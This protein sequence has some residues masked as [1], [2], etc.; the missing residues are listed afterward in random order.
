MMDLTSLPQYVEENRLPLISKAV[1][2]SKTLDYIN[3]QTDIKG[4]AAIN[5][6]DVNPTLQEGGC[7]WND[8]GSAK[9]SQ[10]TINT[11]LLKVNQSFCDKDFI[12]YWQNYTVKVAAGKETLGFEETFTNGVIAK[13]N[14][15]VERM[16]WQ[17]TDAANSFKGLLPILEGEGEVVTVD[18]KS[19]A[20]EAVKAVY[21][22]IPEAVLADAKIFVGAETFRDLMLD[23]VEKNYFH[24]PADGMPEQ[25]II[26]AGTNTEV[27][28]VNGLNGS[29]K[30]VAANPKNLYFGCDMLNDKEE[31]DFFYSKDNREWRLV[32][33]FNGGTEVAYPSEVV[34]G[35][36]A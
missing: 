8:A 2:G 34:V 14:E 26:L 29:K 4:A 10:R 17:G 16:I 11:K 23:M 18:A 12:S 25:K 36:V 32:V 7:G 30:I 19:G 6:V 22:A 3:I 13:I 9:F 1:L 28:A 24:Y 31:F 21:K 15:A 27:V 5:L 33:S 35:S 20:Y